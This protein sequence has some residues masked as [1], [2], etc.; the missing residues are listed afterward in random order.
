MEVLAYV[1]IIGIS[2]LITSL[3]VVP[4]VLIIWHLK[5]RRIRKKMPK[6]MDE[7]IFQNKIKNEEV[8]NE[9]EKRRKHRIW[10]RREKDTGNGDKENGSADTDVSNAPKG[11]RISE[12][13]I[14]KPDDERTSFDSGTDELYCPGSL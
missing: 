10:L 3:I 8:K 2:V 1:I 11:N 4:I 5:L 12:A 14:R 9:R 7:I 13:S 6:N